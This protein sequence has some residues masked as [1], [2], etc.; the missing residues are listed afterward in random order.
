MISNSNIAM[1]ILWFLP[2]VG[3][4]TTTVWIYLLVRKEVREKKMLESPKLH[5]HG[6]L[7]L[8]VT[9]VCNFKINYNITTDSK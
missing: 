7:L 4:I 8:D 2:I 3:I 9:D 6:S 1:L 5:D